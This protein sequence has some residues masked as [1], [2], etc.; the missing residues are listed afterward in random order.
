MYNKH[1][2][3]AWVEEYLFRPRSIFQKILSFLML[4]F[5]YIYCAIVI[6]KRQ[7]AKEIDLK[8]PIIS[9]G[10][11]TVGGSG[12]TPFCI[13]LAKEYENVAIVLRG[14][15]RGSHGT[16]VVSDGTTIKCDVVACGDEAMLYAKSLPKN[17]VIVCEDR[18]EGITV[19]KKMGV[20]IIFL[21]DGFSK[22][23]IKKFDI[24]LKPNPEPTNSFCLPSGPYREPKFLYDEADLTLSEGVDFQRVVT[25]KNPTE[26]MILVTAISKPYRLDPYLPDNLIAKI[27]FSD[28]YMHEVD[29]LVD[30]MKKHKATSILTT[31]KDAVKMISP[32]LTL[33]ILELEIT[34]S[35]HVKEK[36]NAFLSQFR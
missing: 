7:K 24:L 3:I 30:L 2:F 9:I 20:K 31:Q 11:L 36:I 6:A 32:R 22:S 35:Q 21:D 15:K 10:N 34:I 19:A 13:A 14:Y 17:V 1:K 23:H 5:S 18:I 28:H 8:I 4:P 16:L 26:R 25:L 27:A 29:E 33:S 12:K